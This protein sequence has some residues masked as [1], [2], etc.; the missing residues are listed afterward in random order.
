MNSIP[1]LVDGCHMK[2]DNIP[3]MLFVNRDKRHFFDGSPQQE[4]GEG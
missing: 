4:V 1:V 2:W 3:P